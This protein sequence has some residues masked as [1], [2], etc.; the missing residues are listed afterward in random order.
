MALMLF[1]TGETLR[2][3]RICTHIFLTTSRQIKLYCAAL[4]YA[5]LCYAMLCYAML[6]YA[7]LCYAM[8]C[9]AMLCYAMI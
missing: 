3:V 2:K 4:R 5:M 9:Y 8:L 1:L 7:M 6:C